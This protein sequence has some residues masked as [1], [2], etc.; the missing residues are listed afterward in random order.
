MYL[1]QRITKSGHRFFFI[2]L[3]GLACSFGSR[4][5]QTAEVAPESEQTTTTNSTTSASDPILTGQADTPDA[6]SKQAVE[7]G[8][9]L[10]ARVNGQPI[11]LAVYEGRVTQI[12][13]AL[14]RRQP[15]D[16]LD[17]LALAVELRQQVLDGLIEQALIEQQATE[18]GITLSPEDV[19]AEAE[20]F[21]SGLDPQTE[22][23][24]WLES[25]G[26]T[27]ATFLA[28]LQSQLIANRVFEQVTQGEADQAQKNRTFTAWLAE[29]RAAAVIE[30]YVIP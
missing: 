12:E 28:D 30:K 21:V 17:Q 2:V 1:T 6:A 16:E 23:E 9:P 7:D 10:V 13:Q 14:N 15:D 26:L 25:N 22:F 5:N 8:K 20:K 3:I 19:K 27:E 24:R 11:F 29:K 18:L 4:A